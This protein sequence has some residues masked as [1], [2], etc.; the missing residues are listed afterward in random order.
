LRAAD[1]TIAQAEESLASGSG[2]LD[3]AA[4]EVVSFGLVDP[5][6]HT[7]H[8]TVA[9]I[10]NGLVPPSGRGFFRNQGGGAYDSA[11]WIFVDMRVGRALETTGQPQESADL[12]AWNVAQASDNFGILSEL[13][14]RVTAD[15]AGAAP[16]VGFGAG[17]YVLSLLD[18]GQ[19]VTPACG[20][21]ATEPDEP[22]DAGA[23][24]DQDGGNSV[25]DASNSDAGNPPP[26]GTSGCS[27]STSPSSSRGPW[28]LAALA[29]AALVARREKHKEWKSGSGGGKNG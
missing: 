20:A 6:K 9:A 28:A 24:A 13:H 10:Q 22:S 19:P 21:F 4:I 25:Q 27:C 7:A 1:G 16:M 14:D 5:H 17:A 2:W 29:L 15:Y 12:L 3:A 18:R 8:A 11:E 23:D 26:P